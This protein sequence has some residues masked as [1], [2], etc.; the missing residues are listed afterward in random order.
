MAMQPLLQKWLD[1]TVV[2]DFQ[3]GG[4]G[5]VAMRNLASSKKP[6]F[7]MSHPVL[8]SPVDQ[9]TEV[10]PVATMGTYPQ[11]IYV[12]T[13]TG[14]T[15]FKQVIDSKKILIYGTVNS[16]IIVPNMQNYSKA[17]AKLS[18][19]QTQLNEVLYKSSVEVMR[20]VV[21]NHIPM[22]VG[23]PASLRELVRAGKLVPVAT[24]GPARSKI[25]TDTPTLVEQ[26]YSWANDTYGAYHMLYASNETPKEMIALVQENLKKW[27]PTPQAQDLLKNLDHELTADM[28]LQPQ[29][30]IRM[31]TK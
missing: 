14:F 31:V 6:N 12:N 8:N 13:S 1:R 20:D 25:F 26:G 2:I 9:L 28:L 23:A 10:T 11:V 17:V 18:S 3:P 5:A 15:N 21:G 7:L 22:G 27:L 30:I 4:N 16:N 19:G 24:L 29:Q